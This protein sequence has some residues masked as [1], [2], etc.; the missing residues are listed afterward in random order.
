[1]P[2]KDK[3]DEVLELLENLFILE[4]IKAKIPSEEIRKI[5]RID[6]K[7]INAISKHIAK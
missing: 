7:R 5:L 2:Q 3:M 6:K 1:M 4:S